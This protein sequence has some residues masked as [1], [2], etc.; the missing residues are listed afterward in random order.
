MSAVGKVVGKVT[1]GLLGGGPQDSTQESSI[2]V[3]PR[4][5]EEQKLLEQLLGMAAQ[6]PDT[7]GIQ[8]TDTDKQIQSLFKSNLSN[9]LA[10][11]N[12]G[13]V[14]PEALK[15]ATSFIDQ[16]FTKPA[17][18]QLN[19]A[20]SDYLSQLGA[21]Q[22][23]LG[24]Q[25]SDASFQENLFKSLANQRAQLGSQRGQ[26]I[27]DYYTNQP[28]R[29][30][31]TGLQGLQGLGAI[32]Q[33]NAFAP[34]FMNELNQQ[35]FKNRAAL[36]NQLS[37]ERFGSASR[38]VSTSGPS[39]GLMGNINALGSA[40]GSSGNLL[41]PGASLGGLFGA[42]STLGPI[43]GSGGAAS[44]AGG[45][46]GA[47]GVL[48]SLGGAT[49]AGSGGVA[50]AAPLLASDFN[51]KEHINFAAADIEEMLSYLTPYNFNYKGSQYGDGVHTG[52]MAQ[53]LEKSKIGQ[54]LIVQKNGVKYIDPIKTISAL[55]A[56]QSYLFNKMKEHHSAK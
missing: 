20:T 25:V 55:I 14:D 17:E 34:S 46:A 21:Q 8:L 10:R 32:Q 37:G 54:T 43:V 3:A 23:A 22:A 41:G 26:M 42:G 7:S 16:T 2:N 11:K 27:Q 36:L 50:A 38:T 24:R 9:F 13:S 28:A 6:R 47:A 52:V 12:D 1:K 51:V 30:I 45:V 33:Q 5:A 40:F 35:A 31:Q 39:A 44:T 18:Q 19:L 15:S 29:N 4:S 48:G 53:D 49:A 56:T